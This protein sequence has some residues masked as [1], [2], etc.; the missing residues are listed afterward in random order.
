MGKGGAERVIS[1][2]AHYYS[3][4]DFQVSIIMLLTDAVEYE[5]PEKVSLTYI[6][7]HD[8]SNII[9]PFVW[10]AG[11]RRQFKNNKPD[12]VISF[13]AKI[14]LLVLIA[15]LGLKIRTLIS[16]R[17]DPKADGRSIFIK[18]LTVLFYPLSDRIVFQTQYARQC[19][20]RIV[21]QKGIVIPNPISLTI[22]TDS[23]DSGEEMS[24]L[25]INVG[26]LLEQKNQQLLIN[27]F[28][29]VSVKFP[30]YKLHIYGEGELRPVLTELIKSLGLDGK[31]WLMGKTSDIFSKIITA[32]LFVLSS[33]YE[34]LS[35]ALLEA[36][37]LG[38]PCI[39]TDHPGVNELI[40]DRYNGRTVDIDDCDQLAKVIEDVLT[41]YEEARTM[42]N[43][44]KNTVQA[45]SI[46]NVGKKWDE[47]ISLS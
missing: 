29:K 12:T 7:A 42:A 24:K 25:I 28:A 23:Q 32:D 5:L 22:S 30:D 45:Y 46:E 19:F 31:V 38:T 8:S 20:P 10:L 11:L 26:K 17:N 35:N 40:T 43:N 34:G 14:N 18:L 39:S 47:L 1:H 6:S 33:K 15:S 3:K 16:E 41:N 36:M 21:Q 9:K 44:A 27:A 4:K 37:S 2:L 13:F